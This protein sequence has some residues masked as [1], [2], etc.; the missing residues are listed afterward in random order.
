[1]S[2]F[3]P[4]QVVP[5]EP[6]RLSEETHMLGWALTFFILAVLAGLMGF[7]ALAG[8]AAAIAKLLF[9]IF[10]AL[11]VVSFIIRAVRGQS[12]V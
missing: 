5:P 4:D 11:L 10:L 7:Y 9:V 1:M 6:E 2:A 8:V 12:V 3:F